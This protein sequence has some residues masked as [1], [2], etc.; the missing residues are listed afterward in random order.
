MDKA[1][2]YL[3]RQGI[4]L[5]CLISFHVLGPSSGMTTN[6]I[7]FIN[8]ET[9]TFGISLLVIIH[10][11]SI[12][13]SYDYVPSSV[14][15]VCKLLRNVVSYLQE[16]CNSNCQARVHVPVTDTINNMVDMYQ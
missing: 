15:A 10:W 7:L 4:H 13:E 6:I 3:Y 8:Y 16:N 14:T 1:Y 5:L 2:T 11:K 9:I 12:I